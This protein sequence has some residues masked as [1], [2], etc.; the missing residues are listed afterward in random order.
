[1][2]KRIVT[3][4][5]LL[6]KVATG[7]F[8]NI[9]GSFDYVSFKDALKISSQKVLAETLR[10]ADYIS[11]GFRTDPEEEVMLSDSQVAAV[12]KGAEDKFTLGGVLLISKQDY[13]TSGYFLADYVGESYTIQT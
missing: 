13:A 7:F 6:A 12:G 2:I 1:M 10:V 8:I 4:P 11:I 3:F 9:I 5:R